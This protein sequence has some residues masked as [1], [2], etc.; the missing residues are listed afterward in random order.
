M[1]QCLIR[2]AEHWDCHKIPPYA[3]AKK[4]R[5]PED[6]ERTP[7]SASIQIHHSVEALGIL[8]RRNEL[9]YNDCVII[10]HTLKGYL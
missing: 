10:T 1:K 8:H 9:F 5:L 3:F 6:P 2:T 7:H 4:S